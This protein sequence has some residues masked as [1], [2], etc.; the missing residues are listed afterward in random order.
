M[1][2]VEAVVTLTCKFVLVLLPDVSVATMSSECVP[3]DIHISASTV[4]KKV[5]YSAALSTYTRVKPMGFFRLAWAKTCAGDVTD[6][7]LAGV[8]TQT[9]P[10]EESPVGGIGGAGGGNGAV[11]VVGPA[12]SSTVTLGHDP[13]ELGGGVGLGAGLG[14]GLAEAVEGPPIPLPPQALKDQMQAV[15]KAHNTAHAIAEESDGRGPAQYKWRSSKQQLFSMKMLLAEMPWA[16]L[17][18]KSRVRRGVWG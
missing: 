11:P 15:T 12:A 17:Q 14:V 13:E 8:D 1:G 3:G 9:D 5:K 2:E 18:E 6:A 10:V 7:P 4:L 16:D